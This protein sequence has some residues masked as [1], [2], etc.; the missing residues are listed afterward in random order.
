VLHDSVSILKVVGWFDC[1]R[2]SGRPAAVPVRTDALLPPK[3]SLDANK[4]I[5]Q[6]EQIFN[7]RLIQIVKS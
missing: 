5:P 6:S 2:L 1:R 3:N 4:I 7:V